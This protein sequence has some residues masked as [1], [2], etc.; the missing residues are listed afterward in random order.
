MRVGIVTYFDIANYG[1]VL[2]AYA[3]KTVLEEYG[4]H[5]DF[6]RIH[7]RKAVNK[8]LHKIYVGAIT[9]TKLLTSPTARKNHFEIRNL[10]KTTQSGISEETKN[11]F[12]SFVENNLSS[13]TLGRLELVKLAHTSQY[14]YFICGSDQIWSPLSLHLSSYKFL[15]FAP[16]SKRIA[17][18]PSF[19]VES[20]PEYNVRHIKKALK[21]MSY[22]SVRE[23]QGAV[24]I[25]ELTG[26][27]PPVML[28]PTM[29][30]T[31]EQWRKE[32]RKHQT[33]VHNKPYVLAYFFEEPSKEIVQEIMNCASKDGMD[34]LVLM[35]TN[36]M[37]LS[38]GAVYVS[39]DPWEFLYLIDH[40]EYILTNSFHGA[41]FSVLFN[42]KFT[43]FNRK[44]SDNVK[45]TSRIATLLS[46]AGLSACTYKEGEP[47]YKE[48]KPIELGKIVK[49]RQE[50]LQY[51]GNALN[52]EIRN[53]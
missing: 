31:D 26:E 29:L 39:A 9:A 46:T 38:K 32:Y 16:E 51:L 36:E 47:I 52:L 45:Q 11:S 27:K 30:L 37:L 49:K 22:I 13:I 1:S 10:K 3:L 44:H 4:V 42:K 50:S 35:Q 19:G 17:Y 40:A 34:V 12:S 14:D 5:S 43:V 21:K 24:M 41:V 20:I 15:E 8:Y 18:A 48:R 33:K 28:D 2:Q 6:V 25:E 53:E 23:T 7:E